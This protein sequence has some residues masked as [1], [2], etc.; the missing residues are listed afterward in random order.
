MKW[1]NET[2]IYQAGETNIQSIVYLDKEGMERVQYSGCLRDKEKDLTVDE[3]LEAENNKKLL[4]MPFHEALGLINRA[5]EL[6]FDTKG[7]WTEITVEQYDDALGCLPPQKWQTVDGV[8]LFQI[9]EHASGNI[10]AHYAVYKG[11][12]FT[13]HRRTSDKY[14]TLAEEIKGGK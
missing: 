12:Y 8:N 13:A 9:S 1:K 2:V 7:K 10:T 6:V 11:R 4:V 5:E 3:Y 14:E